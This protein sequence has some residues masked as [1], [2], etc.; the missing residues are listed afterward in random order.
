[1]YIVYDHGINHVKIF[2]SLTKRNK[3]FGFGTRLLA[4]TSIYKLTCPFNNDYFYN[5]H[6][7]LVNYD[8]L[9][10]RHIILRGLCNHS[11]CPYKSE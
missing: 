11:A 1:M 7:I 5:V 10:G 6:L 2:Q 9:Y 8:S 3:G 4:L